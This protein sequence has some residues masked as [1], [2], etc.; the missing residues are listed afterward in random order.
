MLALRRPP[1]PQRPRR[2]CPP[3]GL[4]GPKAVDLDPKMAQAGTAENLGKVQRTDLTIAE[5]VPGAMDF[6]TL[7]G[8]LR[9]AKLEDQLKL[10]G[11]FTLLAPDNEAFAALPQGVLRVLL[12]PENSDVLRKIL[13]YH[14]IPQKLTSSE[15]LPGEFVTSQGEPLTVVGRAEGKATIQ[16]AGFGGIPQRI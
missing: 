1:N 10:D 3:T 9:A 13:T 8:A 6:T 2:P 11:P 7:A 4:G 14:I 12:L 5:I 15:I 16:G